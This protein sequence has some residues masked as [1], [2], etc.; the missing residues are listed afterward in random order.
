MKKII[1]TA[2]LAIS[3]MSLFAQGSDQLISKKGEMYLPEAGDWSISVSADPFFN[4]LENVF[5]TKTAGVT[6]QP[7]IN[8]LNG[9]QTIIGKYYVDN[10]TAYRGLLRIGINSMTQQNFVTEDGEPLLLLLRFQP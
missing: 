2:A 7:A 6:V 10:Q 3:T 1:L 9:G 4:Y 5:T 8:F